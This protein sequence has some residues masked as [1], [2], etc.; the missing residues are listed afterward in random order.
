MLHMSNWLSVEQLSGTAKVVGAALVG[1][2]GGL[3]TTA[4]ALGSPE[5]GIFG[6]VGGALASMIGVLSQLESAET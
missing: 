1:A 5:F 3:A 2:V 4:L 6:A